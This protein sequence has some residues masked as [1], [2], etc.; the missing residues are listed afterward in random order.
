MCGATLALLDAGVP[1][2]AP[3]AAVSVG[4]VRNAASGEFGL[5]L[6]ITGTDDHYGDRDFKIV[7]TDSGVTAF[8]L[9]VKKPLSI[10]VLDRE[11]KL[12]KEGRQAILKE[13]EV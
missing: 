8:Q 3:V 2:M 13:M 9:D 7:G 1:I 4:V 6:D 12:A 10:E 11:S 5:L